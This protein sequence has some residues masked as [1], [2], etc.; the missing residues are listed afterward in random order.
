MKAGAET[1]WEKEG[2]QQEEWSRY[3]EGQGRQIATRHN[4]RCVHEKGT[5]KAIYFYAKL[6]V[7]LK[8][9]KQNMQTARMPFNS[10]WDHYTVEYRSIE[11]GPKP[12]IHTG[13]RRI[14]KAL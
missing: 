11:R 4:F 3:R 1:I 10:K 2:D 8:K 9:Q 13:H 6:K 12:H 14:S 5:M 7:S